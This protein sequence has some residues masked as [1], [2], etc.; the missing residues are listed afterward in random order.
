MRIPE[1]HIFLTG[2]MEYV[3]YYIVLFLMVFIFMLVITVVRQR[4]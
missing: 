2:I 1:M 3:L 4:K